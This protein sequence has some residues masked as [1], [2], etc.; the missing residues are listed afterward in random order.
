MLVKNWMSKS[1]I[2]ASVNDSL[3]EVAERLATH[4]I[5][6]L[7]VL[8]KEQLAGVITDRDIKNASASKATSL[9]AYELLYLL[10]RLKIKSIMT[11]APLTVPYDH[12]LEEAANLLIKHKIS[13]AP[14]VDG[15][16]RLAGVITQT[17]LFRAIISL[18]GGN[19]RGLQIA[20]R[21]EDRP[22]SIKDLADIIR[23][24]NGRIVSILTS[25]DD[26]RDGDRKVYFH[27]HGVEHSD[28]ANM[29]DELSQKASLLYIVDHVRNKREIFQD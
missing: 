14:V 1:P 29:Q 10:N 15:E 17:D 6:M 22:G 16:N 24:Y 23:K 3:P 19:T 7:P 27:L 25:Y 5:R 21:T 8:N 9:A 26:V 4:R 28:L 20:L 18:A 12:T 13:G 11:K 2:V